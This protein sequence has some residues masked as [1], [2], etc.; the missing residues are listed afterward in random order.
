[1]KSIKRFFWICYLS[2]LCHRLEYVSGAIHRG[3]RRYCTIYH[4]TL[5]RALWKMSLWECQYKSEMQRY[6]AATNREEH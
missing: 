1:M 3:S 5:S 6:L 2:L 4:T